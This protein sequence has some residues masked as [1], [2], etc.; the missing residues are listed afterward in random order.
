MMHAT[1]APD[2]ARRPEFDV[3]RG[4][5]ALRAT[6]GLSDFLFGVSPFDLGIFAGVTGMLI[7]TVEKKLGYTT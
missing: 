2:K 3:Q 4:G 7:P 5:R 1:R 6:R